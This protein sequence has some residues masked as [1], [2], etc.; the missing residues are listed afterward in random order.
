M[1]KT[2]IATSASAA[3]DAITCTNLKRILRNCGNGIRA[4]LADIDGDEESGDRD[5]GVRQVHEQIDQGRYEVQMGDRIG[6]NVCGIEK[7]QKPK[8]DTCCPGTDKSADERQRAQAKVAHIHKRSHRKES[9]H[10]AVGAF[11]AR[12]VVERIH[13]KE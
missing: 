6:D 3:T 9:E 1:T 2:A 10:L 12:Y 5:D 4:L 8:V 7:T 11:N 13:G